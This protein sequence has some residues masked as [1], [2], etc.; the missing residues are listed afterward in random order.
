MLMREVLEDKPF[1]HVGAGTPATA[2]RRQLS[3]WV[4]GADLLG[5]LGSGGKTVRLR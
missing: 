2:T 3:A 5:R 4:Q 1:R